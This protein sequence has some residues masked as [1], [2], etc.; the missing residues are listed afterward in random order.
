MGA[1]LIAAAYYGTVVVLS[2]DGGLMFSRAGPGVIE[3]P[4]PG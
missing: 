1:S 2:D 4:L 3:V